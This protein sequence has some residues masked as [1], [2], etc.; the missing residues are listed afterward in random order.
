MTTRSS[1]NTSE[2]EDF[3]KKL[4]TL[5]E[6]YDAYL[7]ADIFEN[8]WIVLSHDTRICLYESFEHLSPYEIITTENAN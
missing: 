2:A 3:M 1:H 5:F 6:A 8:L 4:R 7:Y